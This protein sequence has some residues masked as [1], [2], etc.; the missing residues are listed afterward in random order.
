MEIIVSCDTTVNLNGGTITGNTA[1]DDAGGIDNVGTVNG[2]FN[3]VFV[4]TPDTGQR[5]VVLDATAGNSPDDIY[6]P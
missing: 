5:D 4:P 3:G 1:T 6:F 2:N